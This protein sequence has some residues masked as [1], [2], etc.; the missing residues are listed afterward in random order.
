[1]YGNF[2]PVIEKKLFSCV[3]DNFCL[4]EAFDRD[5]ECNDRVMVVRNITQLASDKF[6]RKRL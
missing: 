2:N 5:L 4:M 6:D 3:P 1:M